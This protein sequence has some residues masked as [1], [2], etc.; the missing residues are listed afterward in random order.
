MNSRTIIHGAHILSAIF[1]P[2]YLPVVAV[3]ALF[4]FS[5][6]CLLPWFY[7]LTVLAIVYVFTALAPTVLIHMYQEHEGW[8]SKMPY[9]KNKRV[10]PYV[11]S[12][13]CY[14][15]CYY[16][17]RLLHIPYF[18]GGIVVAALIVQIA[19]AIANV[20]WKISTHTAAIGGIAGLLMAFAD[21]IGYNPVGWLC[22]VIILGGIVGTSR[23]LLRQHSLGQVVTGFLLGMVAAF[24]TVMVI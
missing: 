23:M 14:A 21:I 3:I 20:W 10:V 18:V 24:V 17:M 1:S 22:V 8:L 16:L 6:L 15:S 12:I 19:C 5:Y 2:F 13:A 7:K 4:T 11:I 9:D